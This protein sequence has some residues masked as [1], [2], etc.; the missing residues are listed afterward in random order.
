MQDR[1][2]ESPCT[3]KRKE[4]EGGGGEGKSKRGT[5]IRVG[6]DFQ[7]KRRKEEEMAEEDV[8]QFYAFFSI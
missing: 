6:C 7:Q 4:N 8:D 1:L 5:Q 2:S 3:V